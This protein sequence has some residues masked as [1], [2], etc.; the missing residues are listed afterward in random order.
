MPVRRWERRASVSALTPAGR[1]QLHSESSRNLQCSVCPHSGLVAMLTN[2][3]DLLV[4][5]TITGQMRLALR[6]AELVVNADAR[7]DVQVAREAADA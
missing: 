7:E 4:L 1:T 5:D 3:R 6:D 2:A